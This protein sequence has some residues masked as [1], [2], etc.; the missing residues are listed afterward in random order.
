MLQT[1]TAGVSA[2]LQLGDAVIMAAHAVET[3]ISVPRGL[4]VPGFLTSG[5]LQHVDV[6]LA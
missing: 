2:G 3:N 5:T 1:S 6:C 4:V